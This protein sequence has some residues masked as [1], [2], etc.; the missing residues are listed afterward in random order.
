MPSAADVQVAVYTTGDE[1]MY[2]SFNGASLN[3][4]KLEFL[5]ALL[6]HADL[7]LQLQK[8]L[9]DEGQTRDACKVTV[10]SSS[11]LV[12]TAEEDKDRKQLQGC[13]TLATFNAGASGM[14]LFVCVEVPLQHNRGHAAAAA[15]L[16]AALAELFPAEMHVPCWID[17]SDLDLTAFNSPKGWN[18]NKPMLWTAQVDALWR[19]LKVAPDGRTFRGLILAGPPGMGKSHLVVLLALRCYAEGT[20]VMYLGDVGVFIAEV[21][22]W[23]VA[24]DAALLPHFATLNADVV[25]AAATY[26]ISH[27]TPLQRLLNACNAVVIID[28]HGEAYNRLMDANIDPCEKFS[29]LMPVMY[30]SYRFI[31]CVFAGPNQSQFEREL[32][33]MYRR[34]LCYVLPL[35]DDEAHHFIAQAD[36]PSSL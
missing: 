27:S 7:G 32:N 6:A 11:N 2:H 20:A 31:R 5:K 10:T 22:R 30:D 23:N 26:V 34:A 36:M 35:T 12:P 15:E 17:A 33:D 24:V 9:Q 19:E 1:V 8:L 28:T 3:A 29:L 4:K 14:H 18:P 13:G 16:R 25:P 21:M